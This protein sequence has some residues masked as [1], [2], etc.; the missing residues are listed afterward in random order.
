MSSSFRP[1]VREKVPL[2]IGIAGGTS[3]GKTYSALRFAKGLAGDKKFAVIDTENKRSKSYADDFGFDHTNFK[4]P[5]TAEAYTALIQE[6]DKAGYP[7]IVIDSMSHVWSGIGGVLEQH[8][9]ELD[10]KAGDDQAKRDRCFR[11]AWVKP[12]MRHKQMM[13]RLLQVQAHLILCFRAEHKTEFA[14]NAKGV[15]EARIMSDPLGFHGMDGWMLVC[16]KEVPSELTVLL[17]LKRD[18]P[19]VATLTKIM[20]MHR[21]F[22]PTGQVLDE[23]AGRLMGD[24]SN[25]ANTEKK[26]T[27]RQPKADAPTSFAAT[28]ITADQAREIEEYAESLNVDLDLFHKWIS[29]QWSSQKV[30]EL[31]T[32]AFGPVMEMLEKKDKNKQGAQT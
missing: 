13:L 17:L 11:T 26:T 21:P 5:Y 1:A 4:A 28:C 18:R 6:A 29:K 19:G 3:S 25:G 31:P 8:E 30:G 23:E 15:M 9:S 2:L 16:E 20:G 7:V 12:K 14:R 10:R 27:A 32:E 22:F 24:W